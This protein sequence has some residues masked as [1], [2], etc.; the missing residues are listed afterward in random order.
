MFVEFEDQCVERKG[1][2]PLWGGIVP[3]AGW[4]FS[5][6]IAYN[7]L[8]E[9]SRNV[10]QGVETVVL[11]GGHLRPSSPITVMAR[12]EVWTPFGNIGTDEELAAAICADN[13][14]KQETPERHTP[15]N[16][17]ELQLPMI[18]HLL[19][20][21]SLLIIGA[22]PRDEM[23]ELAAAVVQQARQLGRRLLVLGSTDLTHYGPNY[24]WAPKGSGQE[25]L[26]WVKE[27]NDPRWIER[28]CALDTTGMIEEALESSNACCPG[29]A[30]AAARCARELGSSQAELL[31]Y[32]T[33]ADIRPDASFVGYAGI[34]L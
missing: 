2:Q 33:S 3:H 21:A 4:F 27:E 34:L 16:T 12:G 6:R 18:R 5:G 28:A 32:S 30:A 31:A 1:S 19:P 26:R 10:G 8:Q 14:V 23:L 25:A 11:F 29:A 7:V 15:D 22:P 13:D 20:R 17:I 24:G 9:L